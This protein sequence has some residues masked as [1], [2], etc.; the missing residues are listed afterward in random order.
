[1]SVLFITHNLGVVAEIADRVAV[2]YAGRIVEQGEV[3]RGVRTR[4]C[5]PTPRALLAQHPACGGRRPRSGASPAA[6]P[7][8]VPSPAALPPGCSYAP[9]CPLADDLCR[10]A[11]PP[12]ERGAAGPRGALPSLGTHA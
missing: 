9:R 1:M 8:Q 7:G 10:C 11:M 12:I 3:G 6:I 2:M 4:R 5:I